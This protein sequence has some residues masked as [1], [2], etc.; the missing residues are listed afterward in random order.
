MGDVEG[1]VGD[2]DEEEGGDESRDEGALHPPDQL[3]LKLE[4]GEIGVVV[5][6]IVL[7]D[8]M[9]LVDKMWND[10]GT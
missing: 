10:G 3:Q 8:L 4:V 5:A 7:S 9:D 1:E 2:G 6:W